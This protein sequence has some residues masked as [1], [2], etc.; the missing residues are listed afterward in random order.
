M[1]T[2]D[3]AADVEMLLAHQGRWQR[4][5]QWCG[6]HDRWPLIIT[7]T[8]AAVMGLHCDLSE[9]VAG[10][11][12]TLPLDSGAGDELGWNRRNLG[13]R[14]TARI[15][16]DGT[17]VLADGRVYAT[18]SG[19]ATALSGYPQNGWTVLRTSDGRTLDETRTELRAR[20]EN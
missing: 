14:H 19:A 5:G 17:V 20:R 11:E 13:V 10:F 2:S 9:A 4:V 16:A 6:V 12:A 7:P 8:A 1:A 15:R 3:H 18:P